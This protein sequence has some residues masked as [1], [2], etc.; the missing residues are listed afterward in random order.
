[1]DQGKW[2]ITWAETDGRFVNKKIFKK[3]FF[4]TEAERDYFL[5]NVLRKLPT[6]L[7]STSKSYRPV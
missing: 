4:K 5:D 6:F 1:M 3:A 2:G 7:Y